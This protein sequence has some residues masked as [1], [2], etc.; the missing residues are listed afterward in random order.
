[1]LCEQIMKRNVK[2]L[3][4][5]QT[6]REAARLMRES[7]VGFLPICTA[8]GSVVGAV[9]DRDIVTRV[10]ANS[11]KLDTALKDIMS[12][13]PIVCS[14]EDTLAQAERLMESRKKSRI[15]CI[16]HERHPVGVISLSDIAQHESGERAGELL[17]AVSSREVKLA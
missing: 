1:M 5:N 3:S 14:P 9:T 7:N 4:E 8:G 2:W 13:G 15:V 17:Q 11:G 6:V 16:D 10:V 12:H